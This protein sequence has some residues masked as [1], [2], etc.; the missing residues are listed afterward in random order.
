M[1]TVEIVI[2]V[3]GEAAGTP[4]EARTFD[5]TK[6]DPTPPLVTLSLDDDTGIT[7][8][9]WSIV[10]Q[11]LGA[12]AVLSSE[13]VAA[14]TFTPTALIPGTYLIEC[15]VNGGEAYDRNGLAFLTKYLDIRKPA[16][17]E[18]T[19]FGE[20]YGWALPLA[21][22]IAEVD[23]LGGV[24]NDARGNRRRAVI[25]IVS[26]LSGPPTSNEGDRYILDDSGAPIGSWDGAAANDVVEYN[27]TTWDAETPNEGWVAYVD[28]K[29]ADYRF[30]ND[31]SGVWE[32]RAETP[33]PVYPDNHIWIDAD[34]GSDVTGTGIKAR[35]YAT[36]AYATSQIAVPADFSEYQSQLIFHVGPGVYM[37]DVTMP[38]RLVNTIIGY[39]AVIFGDIIWNHTTQY[40]FAEDPEDVAPLL[41]LTGN[42]FGGLTFYDVTS[43]NID[44]AREA[45]PQKAIYV[46]GCFVQGNIVQRQSGSSTAGN[47]SGYL[48][49]YL[50][51]CTWNPNVSLYT[52]VR[53]GGERESVIEDSNAIL[54][55]TENCDL[56]HVVCGCTLL[57]DVRHTIFRAA[58]NYSLSP[59]N[60]AGS[61]PGIICGVHAVFGFGGMG[62]VDTSVMAGTCVFGNN[63]VLGGYEASV[64]F[65]AA[66]FANFGAA[67]TYDNLTTDYAFTDQAEGVGVDNS[68]WSGNLGSEATAQA[69]LDTVDGLSI[70]PQ[71]LSGAGNPNGVTS[72][73]VNQ[74]YW[75]TTNKMLYVNHD[76][77]TGWYV[78]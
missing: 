21:N 47:H 75:D 65:D 24:A 11:P 43:K 4:G 7:E 56:Q 1:P 37:D 22:L 42:V 55:T 49:L 53:I 6:I 67:A 68:G 26:G 34:N 16:A 77:S 2:D 30:V 20:T 40:V 38:Y 14:P 69:A 62:F 59:V 60:G 13:T 29:D 27:G 73:A 41:F 70:Q 36:L 66:S 74:F 18:T 50:A 46:N 32:S 8:Y 64:K 12:S 72:G 44:I 19:E 76:G 58:M 54:L 39:G 61:Y 31:G 28:D 5:F 63:G 15:I 9:A 78:V 25:D 57:T 33:V 35:P 23:T 10:N 3:A 17:A 45:M 51:Q 48:K 52:T 71:N